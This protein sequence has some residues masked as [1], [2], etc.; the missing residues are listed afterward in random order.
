MYFTVATQLL[1]FDRLQWDKQM[2]ITK[3]QIQTKRNEAVMKNVHLSF[4]EGTNSGND[5]HKLLHWFV[6]EGGD[7]GHSCNVVYFKLLKLTSYTL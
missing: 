7:V 3:T 2:S 5:K 6:E 4:D 1:A